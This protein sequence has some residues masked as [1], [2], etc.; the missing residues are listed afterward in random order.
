MKREQFFKELEK[1]RVPYR[2]ALRA[3]H[4]F[5]FTSW[6][7]EPFK[8]ARLAFQFG[9]L[10]GQRASEAEKLKKKQKE[11]TL[12]APGYGYLTAIIGKHMGDEAFIRRM[13]VRAHSLDKAS[14]ELREAR[15]SAAYKEGAVGHA[16][17]T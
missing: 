2:F 6:Q 1:L 4:L 5:L 9:F 10:Q 15:T 16:E 8:L 14:Q 17:K 13:L 11:L 3:S 12:H 7:R